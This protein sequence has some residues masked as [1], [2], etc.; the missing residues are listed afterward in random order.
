[1]AVSM[2]RL[3]GVSER[4]SCWLVGISRSGN[5]YHS[6]PRAEVRL[7]DAL[8]EYSRRHPR[9]GYRKAGPK[10]AEMLGE[11]INHKRIERIWRQ[12]GLTVPRKT[13]KRRRGKGVAKPPVAAYPT[14]VWC[15]DFLQDST[16]S[17]RKLRLFAVTDEFTRESLL[18]EIGRSFKAVD[19]QAGLKRLFRKH[20]QPKFIR[21]DNGP[22]FVAKVVAGWLETKGVG[23]AYI[24]P[25][26]PWQNGK[27]ESFNG[28]FRAECLDMEVF[29]D[30]PDAR[31]IVN[32]WRNHYNQIRPHGSLGYVAPAIFKEQWLARNAGALPPHPRDLSLKANP[33]EAERPPKKDGPSVLALAAALGS[34]PRVALSSGRA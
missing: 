22:E 8:R 3:R 15:M 2:L 13:R 29:Y 31:K 27:A 12:A 1:M 18:I 7:V 25:G 14:H 4:R 6:S 17:G 30:G 21:C 10:V 23:T 11:P 32:S 26:K 5:R 33:D 9:E 16:L 28:R 20:G 19:V 24:E 34:R